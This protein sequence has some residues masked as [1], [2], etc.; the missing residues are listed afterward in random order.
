LLVG[1]G[2]ALAN[3]GDT[4]VSTRNAIVTSFDDLWAMFFE[5]SVPDLTVRV[6]D[7]GQLL[8]SDG[9][10]MP[11]SSRYAQNPAAHYCFGSR[12]Q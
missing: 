3:I 10:R 2:R 8:K 5:S 9:M 11:V 12:G 4:S 1:C 6:C 7:S